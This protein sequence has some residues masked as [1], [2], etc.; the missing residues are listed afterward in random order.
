MKKLKSK[1][2]LIDG[3]W[4]SQFTQGGIKVLPE[5]IKEAGYKS[6]KDVSINV[7]DLYYN[8]FAKRIFKSSNNLSIAD[9]K[10]TGGNYQKIIKS[11]D[12]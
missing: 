6:V 3:L 5:D 10:S 1:N 11:L 9:V 2:Q 12:L 4:V 7:G 8:F